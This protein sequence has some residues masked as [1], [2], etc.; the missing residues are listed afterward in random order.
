[1]ALIKT[2]KDISHISTHNLHNELVGR[3]EESNRYKH[4]HLSN[5]GPPSRSAKIALMSQT[6]I[7]TGQS[8]PR[9]T[10]HDALCTCISNETKF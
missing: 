10:P 9:I 1:M 8:S 7:R 4:Y 6:D 3:L 2:V 5:D